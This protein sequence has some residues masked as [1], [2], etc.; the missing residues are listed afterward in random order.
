[1]SWLG[2]DTDVRVDTWGQKPSLWSWAP[3]PSYLQL[4]SSDD[5]N[6]HQLLSLTK[7]QTFAASPTPSPPKVSHSLSP[8][9]QFCKILSVIENQILTRVRSQVFKKWERFQSI[10]QILEKF[11]RSVRISREPD[12]EEREEQNKKSKLAE[13]WSGLHFFNLKSQSSQEHRKSLTK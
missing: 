11:H 7:V 13:T 3:S 8:S 10:K 4:S 9:D 2:T 6:L 5:N 1:M 12:L